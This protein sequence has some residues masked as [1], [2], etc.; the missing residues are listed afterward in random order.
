MC[1]CLSVY[2]WEINGDGYI[3]MKG[4]DV[5]YI[6]KE[7]SIVVVHSNVQFVCVSVTGQ[8]DRKKKSEGRKPRK[9]WK[10]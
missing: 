4:Y 2:M 3:R 6:F 8:G 1:V 9:H 5:T 7:H 10:K